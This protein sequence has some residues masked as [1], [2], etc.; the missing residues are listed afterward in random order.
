MF[1]RRVELRNVRSIE[2]LELSCERVGGGVRGWTLLLGDNG[3][4]KSTV[5]RSIALALAGSE[6]LPDL[7]GKPETWI[8]RGQKEAEIILELVTAE[9]KERRISMRLR[10]GWPLAKTFE[11]NREMLELLD[12]AL[13][14]A[15]RNYFVAGYGVSRRMSGELMR[16]LRS[17]AFTKENAR[18][19]NVATLFQPDAP[20]T[21]LES[22]AMDLDYRQP[23]QAKAILA[24][25][26]DSLLPDV[27]FLKIDR[28]SR[29]MIFQTADGPLPMGQL[30]DGY[31]NIISWT[32]DLLFRV[33]ETFKDFKKPLEARGLL[34]IDEI[35]L[36]LHPTWQRK[37]MEFLEKKLPNFQI[38]ATT[39]SPLTAHQAGEGEL[40]ML[41]RPQEKR[42]PEL[43]PFPGEP[44]RMLL[45]QFLL[46]PAFELDT[47]D[48]RHY[49]VL[50]T[51]YAEMRPTKRK[52]ASQMRR[53]R[54]IESEL[55]DAP[56]WE[57][58]SPLEKRRIELL[59]GVRKELSRIGK[60]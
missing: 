27:N 20:L 15:A 58:N 19:L 45:H 54:E 44:R 39:H 29:Q 7:L 57:V 40:F 8:R 35:D 49:E 55:E 43:R 11:E 60:R 50:K 48:S 28:K 30:S 38:I 46:S 6:A 36:H 22:W 21:S 51:E 24:S 42:P 52:T 41:K 53:M 34:L 23:R 59:A 10:K 3:T 12:S 4:G 9:G 14:Y 26:F 1:L 32:G 25:T 37:L 2:R 5:L 56:R 33:T 31:Q 18:A 16:S 13:S 47:A 17:G